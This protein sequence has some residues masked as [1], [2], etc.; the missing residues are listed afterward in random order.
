MKYFEK[1]VTE[2][3]DGEVAT[4]VAFGSVGVPGVGPHAYFR[5]NGCEVIIPRVN[6]AEFFTRMKALGELLGH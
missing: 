6:E 2:P 1:T 4:E 3:R 5:I